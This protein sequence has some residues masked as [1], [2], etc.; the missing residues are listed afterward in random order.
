MQKPRIKKQFPKSGIEIKPLSLD[1]TERATAYMAAREA[2]QRAGIDDAVWS[3]LQI[4]GEELAGEQSQKLFDLTGKR[5]QHLV[6][7]AAE[8]WN[9][10]EEKQAARRAQGGTAAG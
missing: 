2:R 1:A 3:D 9:R 7:D 5:P 4:A 10:F 8:I 6:L